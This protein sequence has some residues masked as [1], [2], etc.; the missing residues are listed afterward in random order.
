MSLPTASTSSVS[1]IINPYLAQLQQMYGSFDPNKVQTRRRSY[2]S[3]VPYPTAGQSSFS[4]FGQ[5]I[6]TS[7]RQ[8]TNIQRSGHLDN[9]LIVKALR[10][11]YFITGQNNNTWAGTDASTLFSDIVNG[12]FTAGVLRLII[13]SKE[14]FQIP[15]PFLYAPAAYGIPELYTAGTQGANISRGPYA[16]PGAEG[17][18]AT[19]LVDPQF[20]IGSD[21]NFMVTIE[22]P[23]GLVPVIGT[24]VVTSG[25]VLYIGIEFDGI[26][27][28]PLQ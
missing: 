18:D 9:P 13:S 14:W 24:G 28:R 17:K 20:L 12:L 7:N 25:T 11:R 19:Y 10:T 26:E 27:I 21:Q 1:A 6:G 15:T 23:S 3:F 2:Y 8:L 5:T 4:F 16:Y 22:Y